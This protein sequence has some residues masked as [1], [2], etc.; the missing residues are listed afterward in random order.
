MNGTWKFRWVPSVYE[1]EDFTG[2]GY[3]FEDFTD[4]NVP[5]C[6]QLHG[7]DR[8]QYQSSPYTFIFDPPYVP[9]KNP[10]AGYCREFDFSVKE[11]RRYE[12]H[13]EG[14]DSCIYVW[15]NGS[16]VGYGEV[17]H[18]DSAFDAT[19]YL[20]NGKNRLCVMV[21]KWCSG[22]YLDDQ[23]KLRLSGV[24]RDVYLLERSEQGIRDF[25]LMTTNEGSVQLTVEAPSPVEVQLMDQ[26]KMIGS[27]IAYDGKI[28]FS[29]EKPALWSAEKPYLY[30]I[31]LFSE[32]EYIRHR[33]GFREV[34]MCIPMC[35][36]PGRKIL[37][38]LR[39]FRYSP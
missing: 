34:H 31:L 12:L 32:G 9:E 35:M 15:L 27:G 29:I 18:N 14:K 17:P 25:R 30:E 20:K 8:A 4:V 19:S 23:D 10:A 5:E 7:A 26:G 21:L 28:A 36:P 13:F 16:F 3:D 39:S 6:W 1:L 22:S 2:A 33:F 37:C 11:G 38:S 24:F